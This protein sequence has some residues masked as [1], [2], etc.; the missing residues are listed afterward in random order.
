MDYNY[1]NMEIQVNNSTMQPYYMDY[2]LSKHLL[3]RMD[4]RG[5]S[6]DMLEIILL[7]GKTIFKEGLTY[8]YMTYKNLPETMSNQ[9]RDRMNNI[10][11]VVDDSSSLI[12]TAY[13]SRNGLKHVKKK[14]KRLANYAA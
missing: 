2:L 7:Y 11:L 14:Q 12:L 8:Y 10:V 3:T 1:Q 5:I 9:L 6:K 13:R 4:Q